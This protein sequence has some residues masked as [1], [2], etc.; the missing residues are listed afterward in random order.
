MHQCPSSHV[1]SEVSK[2]AVHAPMPD[3]NNGSLSVLCVSPGPSGYRPLL[4]SD[5]NKEC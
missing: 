3:A 5:H 1:V 2:Y 4:Q